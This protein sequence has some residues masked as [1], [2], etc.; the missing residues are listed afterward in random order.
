M[1]RVDKLL[2][3]LEMTTRLRR[4]MSYRDGWLPFPLSLGDPD[5]VYF[6]RFVRLAL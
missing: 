3:R 6:L 4:K 5:F 1:L 2:M